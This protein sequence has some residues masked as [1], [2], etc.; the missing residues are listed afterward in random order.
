MMTEHEDGP[1]NVG[2]WE[3]SHG[4]WMASIRMIWLQF[5]AESNAQED[6]ST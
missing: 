1:E 2:F 5:A 6:D 4:Q 3:N